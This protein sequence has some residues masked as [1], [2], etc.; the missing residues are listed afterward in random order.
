MGWKPFHP[1][2][3]NGSPYGGLLGLPLALVRYGQAL[4]QDNYRLVSPP[5]KDWLFSEHRN[6]AGKG[7]GMCLS[8]FAGRFKEEPYVAHAG[9]GGGYYSEIRLYRQRKRGSAIFF[10]RSGLRDERYLDKVDG[11]AMGVDGG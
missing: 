3:V 1:F 11:F 6:R 7:T 10:N 5:L 4:L 2:Y 8:W 9:G